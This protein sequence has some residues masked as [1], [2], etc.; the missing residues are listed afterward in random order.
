MCCFASIV[1]YTRRRAR[2]ILAL[3]LFNFIAT[4]VGV[5]AK[6]TL[7][8]CGLLFHACYAISFIGGFYVYIMLDY[9]LT[10]ERR[11]ATARARKERGG[12]EDGA[13]TDTVLLVIVSIPFFA[14]FVMGI[15]SAVLLFKI[16]EEYD[17][18][19]AVE[20]EEAGGAEALR[21]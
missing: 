1:F 16:D 17:A 10:S 14:L 20:E 5:R 13:L 6:L 18:R 7:S 8:Y 3:I 9:F 11:A 19:K 15:Y 4:M 12:V 2:I 21:Q